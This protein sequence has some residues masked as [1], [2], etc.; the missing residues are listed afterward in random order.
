MAWD[1]RDTVKVNYSPGLLLLL[2]DGFLESF[3]LS[4]QRTDFINTFVS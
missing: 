1:K 2:K 4:L 3:N